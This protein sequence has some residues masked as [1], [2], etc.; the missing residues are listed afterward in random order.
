MD[1]LLLFHEESKLKDYLYIFRKTRII[2]LENAWKSLANNF[3]PSNH[4]LWNF[5]SNQDFIN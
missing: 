5:I 2:R 4:V 1:F 3:I